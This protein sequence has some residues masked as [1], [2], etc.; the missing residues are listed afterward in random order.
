MNCSWA[1]SCLIVPEYQVYC[2]ND[3][4]KYN[5]I[6]NSVINFVF[7]FSSAILNGSVMWVIY[8]QERLQTPYYLILL[9]LAVTDFT[10][11]LVAQPLHIVR[12]LLLVAKGGYTSC[13]LDIC[14]VAIG[15]TL[16]AVSFFTVSYVTLER[17]LAI[18]Y[19]FYHEE[20]C[21]RRSSLKWLAMI[22]LIGLAYG[23][24][25]CLPYKMIRTAF[26]I[27]VSA[28]GTLFLIWNC[29]AYSRI[30]FIA[31]SIQRR[32]RQE[33]RRFAN[34]EKIVKEAK[35]AKTTFM[36]VASLL[37]FYGPAFLSTAMGN[38]IDTFPKYL[39]IWAYTFM[40]V[41]STVNPVIYCYFCQEIGHEMKR[42]W[43]HV[44]G[45]PVAFRESSVKTHGISNING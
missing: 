17:Y 38:Q 7:A 39:N 27:M 21:T 45:R 18:F 6:S 43:Y 28:I 3:A 25:G 2:R 31:R 33:Q 16:I 26:T 41:N 8:F 9:S 22:W 29:F 10:A 44:R 40:L 5:I 24:L 32:I 1:V 23:A 12:I 13:A 4:F 20:Q 42:L 30:F 15:Y 35:A 36:V 19:P 34:D 14:T 11:G 37:L